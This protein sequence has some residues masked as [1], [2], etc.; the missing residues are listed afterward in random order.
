MTSPTLL[1][2]HLPQRATTGAPVI[3]HRLFRPDM[4]DTHTR[5]VLQGVTQMTPLL[6]CRHRKVLP[7][8]TVPSL[9]GIPRKLVMAV[10]I[11]LTVTGLQQSMWRLQAGSRVTAVTS[12]LGPTS[13]SLSLSRTPPEG[14]MG[15]QTLHRCRWAK[16]A[17]RPAPLPVC[18]PRTL[19]MRPLQ[20]VRPGRVLVTIP[21]SKVTVLVTPLDRLSRSTAV[22][23]PFI[24]T[25]QS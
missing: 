2:K 25:Q 1:L 23:A 19:V 7:P 16:P 18:D 4:V 13:W 17:P 6:V 10:D 9:V 22:R 11:L 12:V 5:P 15:L 21:L 24:S 20:V 3:L 8:V 14:P